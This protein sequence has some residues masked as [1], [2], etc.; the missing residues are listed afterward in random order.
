MAGNESGICLDSYVA[1]AGGNFSVGQRQIL[2]LARAI[3]RKTK[4]L[5][6]DEAT[7]AIGE[8]SLLIL[9][10]SWR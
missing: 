5:I 1:A 3:V 9:R 7:A 10:C 2:S 4:V 8:Y 6:M